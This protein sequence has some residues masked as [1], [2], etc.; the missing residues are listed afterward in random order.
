MTKEQNAE[1]VVA[2]TDG[3]NLALHYDKDRMT[4]MLTMANQFAKSGALPRALD[5]AEKVFVVLQTGFEMGLTPMESMNSLYIVNGSIKPYGT[6]WGKKLKENGWKI[7]Y[8]DKEDE[9]GNPIEC[10]V[11]I[12]KGGETHEFTAKKSQ[13]KKSTAMGFAPMEKLRF[14]ALSRIV[15]FEVPEIMPAGLSF[16]EEDEP[17][18][19]TVTPTANGTTSGFQKAQQKYEQKTEEIL[20]AEIVN[21][22]ELQKP[23][24]EKPTEQTAERREETPVPSKEEPA[25]EILD[26]PEPTP[27]APKEK[28]QNPRGRIHLRIQQLKID[29]E[30][31]KSLLK[32]YT[33]KDDIAD[34]NDEECEKLDE[35]FG[36][37]VEK[38]Q[39]NG[40]LFNQ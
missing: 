26:E 14:H 30:G 6:F 9:Q 19:I 38:R 40:T 31:A 35:I 29:A 12:T 22:P 21:E 2:K 5:N 25:E 18:T 39:K 11:V 13:L 23:L 28:L 27:S 15:Q 4:T 36:E 16:T 24:D 1:V 32:I 20:E 33:D 34:L 3:N 17:Q 8:N 7:K 10:H 37:M